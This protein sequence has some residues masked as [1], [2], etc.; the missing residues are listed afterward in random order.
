MSPRACR[1]ILLTGLLTG[2]LTLAALAATA[3][4]LFVRADGYYR[5]LNA[6]RL[7]PF[8]ISVFPPVSQAEAEAAKQKGNEKEKDSNGIRTIV[9]LGDSRAAA[10]HM[11]PEPGTAKTNCT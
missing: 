5:E 6:T 3:W 1:L 2:V 9:I 4:W 8:G 7:D 10:W 11:Q